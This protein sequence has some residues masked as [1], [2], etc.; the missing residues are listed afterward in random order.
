MIIETGFI[1]LYIIYFLLISSLALIAII[2]T[3]K[4]CF[5]NSNEK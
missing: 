3:I 2:T 5:F 1:K 4:F